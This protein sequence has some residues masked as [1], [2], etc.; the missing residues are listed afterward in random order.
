M[1]STHTSQS[2]LG[3]AVDTTQLSH[4]ARS[5]RTHT[6]EVWKDCR[7]G[8][9]VAME[10]V[11]EEARVRAGFSS[12]I[13]Y[14]V[15]IRTTSSGNVK[16]IAG[17]TG[18]PNAAPIEN[19]GRGHVRHPVFGNRDVW[20][21]KNSPPAFLAPAFD[22]HRERVLTEVEDVLFA[23]VCRAIGAR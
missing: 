8:L 18:A 20:T 12:R 1:P 22:A 4:L 15:K 23:S 16:V 7:A 3:I 14:T 13:E 19:K 6:P 17:G 21:D 2:G 11:A 9:R 5:I 10:P